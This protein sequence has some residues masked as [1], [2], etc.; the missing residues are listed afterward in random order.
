MKQLIFA[1]ALALLASSASHAEVEVQ[2]GYVRATAPGA[3]NSAGFMVL[4]NNGKAPLSLTGAAS[5]SA[6]AVEL[7][8]HVNENGVLRMRREAAIALPP[9]TLVE[10]KPG[11]YHLMLLGLSEPLKEGQSVPMRLTF[12]DGS[13]QQLSLPVLRHMPIQQHDSGHGHDHKMGH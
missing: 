3:P 5:P 1:A 9:G 7:H 12:S 13:E 8:N 4:A 10:L 11:S 2:H 6:T